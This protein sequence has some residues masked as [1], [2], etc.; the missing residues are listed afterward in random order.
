M[1]GIKYCKNCKH[2]G[3]GRKPCAYG[4]KWVRNIPISC[5]HFEGELYFKQKKKVNAPVYEAE[6]INTNP[7][8]ITA[9][10]I[11]NT[12]NTDWQEPE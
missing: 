5:E 11:C 4:H 1:C 6:N 8:R 7:I 9:Y 2:D 3:G 10:E 12:F